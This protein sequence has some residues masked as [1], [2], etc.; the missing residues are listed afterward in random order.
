MICSEINGEKK[1]NSLLVMR[2]AA[3]PSCSF[4]FEPGLETQLPDDAGR[5]AHGL[6][7]QLPKGAPE[8][9]CVLRVAT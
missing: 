3:N 4:S 5:S 1:G 8:A 9:V 6:Q 7:P 2:R